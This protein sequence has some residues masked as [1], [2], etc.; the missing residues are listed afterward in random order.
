MALTSPEYKGEV[1][2]G[3]DRV[4]ANDGVDLVNSMW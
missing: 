1:D 2:G 4:Q 3:R